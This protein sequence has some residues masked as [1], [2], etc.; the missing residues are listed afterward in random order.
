MIVA[1]VAICIYIMFIVTAIYEHYT[2]S[3]LRVSEGLMI[4]A[5]WLMAIGCQS[6]VAAIVTCVADGY[7]VS[8]CSGDDSHLCRCC[9][10]VCV[11]G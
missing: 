1:H 3:H 6:G 7:R 5:T 2:Y 11:V 10:S 8:V 9:V 4:V